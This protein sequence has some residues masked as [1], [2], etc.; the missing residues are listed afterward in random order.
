MTERALASRMKNLLQNRGFRAED[1]NGRL[2]TTASKWRRRFLMDRLEGF[3][4][5][6]IR[7]R[8]RT[9]KSTRNR[10][11]AGEHPRVPP[12]GVRAA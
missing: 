1:W 11:S 9:T 3:M 12:T 10:A 2:G 5:S 4:T 6:R 7:A 8:S